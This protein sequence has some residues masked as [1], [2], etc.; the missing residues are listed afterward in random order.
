M[1]SLPPARGDVTGPGPEAAEGGKGKGG[2]MAALGRDPP[3]VPS[4]RS[5]RV[6]PHGSA[7]AA[8]LR[9]RG[10]AGEAAGAASA[11]PVSRVGIERPQSPSELRGL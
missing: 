5:S 10:A 4:A 3:P 2:K 9:G 6:S 7:I 11:L 8:V 1:T